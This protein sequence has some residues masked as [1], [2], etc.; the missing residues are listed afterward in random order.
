MIRR[1]PRSTRTDT[2]FPYTTLFRSTSWVAR[3]V[4]RPAWVLTSLVCSVQS[5]IVPW[6]SRKLRSPS[7]PATDGANSSGRSLSARGP[8]SAKGPPVLVA[9]LLDAVPSVAPAFRGLTKRR[10]ENSFT[11]GGADG[12]GGGRW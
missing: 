6:V 4:K 1:P 3:H 5:I 10:W 12:R 11:S 2:L 9:P 7:L 8:A